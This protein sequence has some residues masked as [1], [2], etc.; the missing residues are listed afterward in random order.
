MHAHGIDILYEADRDH[1]AFPVTY[2]LKLQLFPADD[3][4]FHQDLSHQGSLQASGDDCPQLVLIINQT[5]AG[6]AH[7]ISGAQNHGITQLLSYGQSVI[8]RIS[9]LG[10]GHLNAE[11]VHGILELDTVL[12]SLYGIHLHSYDL[13]VIFIQ[14]ALFIEFGA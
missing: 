5:A 6:A 2:H 14:N 3:G 8:H 13:Y 11:R 9:H 7:G 1:V 10:A 12:A 4:L